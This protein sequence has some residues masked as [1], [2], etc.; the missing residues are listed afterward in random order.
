MSVSL[1]SQADGVRS[2]DAPESS[3]RGERVISQR[4]GMLDAKA[5]IDTDVGG[6]IQVVSITG[7]DQYGNAKNAEIAFSN[8]HLPQA[9]MLV[10]EI[11][12]TGKVDLKGAVQPGHRSFEATEAVSGDVTLDR[13]HGRFQLGKALSMIKGVVAGR[14]PNEVMDGAVAALRAQQAGAGR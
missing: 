4:V 12:R 9:A 3:S 13:S 14:S 6:P 10:A 11:E 8:I 1:L 7:K 2:S 5:S